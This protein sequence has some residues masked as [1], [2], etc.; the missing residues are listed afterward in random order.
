MPS[1]VVYTTAMDVLLYCSSHNEV[2]TKQTDVNICDVATTGARKRAYLVK[3][4]ILRTTGFCS[5]QNDPNNTE[6]EWSSS[7]I[8]CD[9]K[10]LRDTR[11]S[12]ID[13]IR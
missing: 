9:I 4:N 12:G 7:I 2:R 6:G 3:M 1:C 10:M 8:L 11:T 13:I 5:E